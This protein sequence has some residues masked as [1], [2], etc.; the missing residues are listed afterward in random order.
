MGK[1]CFIINGCLTSSSA[2]KG[3][4]CFIQKSSNLQLEDGIRMIEI[5]LKTCILKKKTAILKSYGIKAIRLPPYHP[6]FLEHHAQF[7]YILEGYKLPKGEF[8]INLKL[9]SEHRCSG[10]SLPDKKTLFHQIKLF[11]LQFRKPILTPVFFHL[12][13]NV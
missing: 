10:P 11:L 5:Y 12:S 2:S 7:E 9:F 8:C 3:S 4:N 13:M 6:G 1:N